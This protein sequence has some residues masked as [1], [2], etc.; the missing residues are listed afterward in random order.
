MLSV[1]NNMLAM[2]ADR[3]LKT[4]VKKNSKNTE[5]LSSGY[6][7]NRGADDAAGLSLS[8]KMR[9][10]IRGL[11]QSA[12]NISEG[13][14]YVQTAEGALTEVQDMLQRMNELAV[15][16]ANGTNTEEDRK[17]IDQE[18]QA[19]KKEMDRIFENTTFNEQRIWDP[20]ERKQIG[21]EKKRAVNYVNTYNSMTVTNNNYNVIPCGSFTVHADKDDGVWVS[22]KDYDG[23]QRETEKVDW[24]TLNKNNYSFEMSDYFGA[25]DGANADLYD[26]SGKA[27]FTHRVAFD[28]IECATIE[29][30]VENIDGHIMYCS[31]STTMYGSWEGS[32][33]QNKFKIIDT[34]LT[35]QSSYASKHLDS[36]NGHDFDAKDDIFLEP[37]LTVNGK[38]SN[39]T[40]MPS[41]DNESNNVANAK[42]STTGWTFSFDMKGVGK[43]DA[44]S[45]SITYYSNDSDAE[46][47][48]RWW[49]Y[50]YYSDGTKVK[51]MIEHSAAGNLGGLM[52]TLTGDKGLLSK[53]ANGG[54]GMNDAIGTIE[55]NF[56]LTSANEFTY[57]GTYQSK[58]VGSFSLQ[59]TVTK[60]DTE[61]T[62]LERVKNALNDTTILDFQTA[63]ASSDSVSFSALSP[64]NK[65]IDAPIWGGTCGFYV[66]GGTESGEHISMKYESLSILQM[67]MQDTNVLTAEDSGKAIDTIKVALEIVSEQRSTFGAYQN[68]LEHAYHVNT[69]TE[70]N[71]Q[72]AESV[73]RDTDIADMMVSYSNNNILLQAGTSMLTQANQQADYILQLLR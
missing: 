31:P 19:L 12:D 64:G 66:Q 18:V 67:D 13:V 14:G 23:T 47:E 70:E 30:I 38:K 55:I 34:K 39:L 42:K 71:T 54:K 4:N 46:D 45:T 41:T 22:W 40:K 2:N 65:K 5:K 26:S 28:P 8:E 32:S 20:N 3:Q 9:R 25:K 68:R 56:S 37:S 27:V 33:T 72:S 43:V 24:D 48:G 73:I 49:Q 60:D 15:K 6:R 50:H 16:S 1:Q 11:H 17:Y 51:R 36:Q 58:S 62:I 7:I 69:N 35:Y 61:A 21:T 53:T 44:N 29:D 63:G 10:Q 52:S 59:F 57:G